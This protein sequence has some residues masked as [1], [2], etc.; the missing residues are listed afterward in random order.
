MEGYHEEYKE[1]KQDW[2]VKYNILNKKVV[3]QFM[4]L[5]AMC[6]EIDCPPNSGEQ[7]ENC[8]YGSELNK[9]EG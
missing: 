6:N 7:C 2:P 1:Y 8:I 5:M 9:L 3:D 4:W